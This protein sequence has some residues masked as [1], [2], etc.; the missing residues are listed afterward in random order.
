MITSGTKTPLLLVSADK[1]SSRSLAQLLETNGYSLSV[2]STL[3]SAQGEI[4][5]LSPALILVDRDIL[6]QETGRRDQ[7]SPTIP[8]IVLQPFDKSCGPDECL[9]EL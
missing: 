1:V 6:A 5:R 9:T 2:A 3:T 8:I 4:R 7:F